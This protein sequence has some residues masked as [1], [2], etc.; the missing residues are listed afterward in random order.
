MAQY[1]AELKAMKMAQ[2]LAYLMALVKEYHLD[3][4][5]DWNLALMSASLM[6]KSKV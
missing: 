3:P 5:M 6:E 4:M 2:N 1:L